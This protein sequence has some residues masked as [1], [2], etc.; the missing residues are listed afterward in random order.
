MALCNNFISAT[1]SKSKLPS[2]FESSLFCQTCRTNQTLVTNLLANYL[3]PADVSLLSKYCY[4]ASHSYSGSQL[5]YCIRSSSSL[6]SIPGSSLSSCV[7][8]LFAS[9]PRAHQA[10]GTFRSITGFRRV[11]GNKSFRATSSSQPSLTHNQK[12]SGETM[13]DMAMESTRGPL[14]TQHCLDNHFLSS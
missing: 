6:Q 11:A 5:Y 8:H 12:R 2:T 9:S 7:P 14:C 13:G 1:A 3:P 10:E 4:T